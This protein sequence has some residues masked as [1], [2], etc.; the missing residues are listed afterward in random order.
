MIFN[1][2]GNELCIMIPG[3]NLNNLI[4]YVVSS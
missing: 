1:E 2:H 3:F 4:P